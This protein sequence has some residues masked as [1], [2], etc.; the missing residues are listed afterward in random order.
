M[1][2]ILAAEGNFA[3]AHDLEAAWNALSERVSLTLLCGYASAHF[4]LGNRETMS[5]ICAAHTRVDTDAGDA[6]GR[7]LVDGADAI[8]CAF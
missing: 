5:M 2:D 8:R 4:A 1:V 3:A 7:W 6:L